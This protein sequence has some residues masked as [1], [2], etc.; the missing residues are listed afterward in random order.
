MLWPQDI[1]M[2]DKSAPLGVEYMNHEKMAV[3]MLNAASLLLQMEENRFHQWKE[4]AWGREL[5]FVLS[6]LLA[7]DG[8]IN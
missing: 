1:F 8:K 3:D 2:Y 7:L 6:V 5:P 4:K